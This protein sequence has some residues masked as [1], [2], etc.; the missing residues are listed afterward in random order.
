M[1]LA[2]EERAL[3][4]DYCA[5]AADLLAQVER[6]VVHLTP[7]MPLD[8]ISF[9]RLTEDEGYR[10]L[11][12]LKRFEELQDLAQRKLFRLVLLV[13]GLDSRDF[14]AAEL[15]RYVDRAGIVVAEPWL[16]ATSVRNTLVHDYPLNA[17]QQA[18]RA[19]AAWNALP[20]LREG[21]VSALDYLEKGLA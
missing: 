1:T 11:A 20:V 21:T 9:N 17:V 13:D 6:V 12:F 19:N 8:A 18:G 7:I 15:V 3:A 14:S 4:R 16:T 2:G 5:A 10:L